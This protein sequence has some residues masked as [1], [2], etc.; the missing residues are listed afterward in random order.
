MRM[1]ETMLG[2]VCSLWISL[3]CIA[4][5]LEWA[6]WIKC[7]SQMHVILFGA[8]EQNVTHNPCI[9]T[10]IPNINKNKQWG[11]RASVTREEKNTQWKW[12]HL[13]F[14]QVFRRENERGR[15][16]TKNADGLIEIII[17][18]NG[19]DWSTSQTAQHHTN[20]N[21]NV[22]KIAIGWQTTEWWFAWKYRSGTHT[23]KNRFQ[24][25]RAPILQR[26]KWICF[27]HFNYRQRCTS[28][29]SNCLI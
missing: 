15:T 17:R 19:N 6:M 18:I 25:H 10:L 20:L 7:K 28:N 22:G 26:P 29:E 3:L 2:C 12:T 16:R 5:E 23:T 9:A 13:R 21:F 27:S 8:R 1:D 4:L 24:E 14:F 11:L